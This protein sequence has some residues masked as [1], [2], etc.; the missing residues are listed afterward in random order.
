MQKL[1]L[2]RCDDDPPSGRPPCKEG[3]KPEDYPE[4][5]VK[6]PEK[7]DEPK[8]AEARLLAA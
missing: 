3:D 7:E 2:I 5:P 1:Y 4:H 6:E 8:P